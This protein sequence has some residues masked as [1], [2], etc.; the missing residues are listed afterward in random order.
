MDTATD[1]RAISAT[2]N[3]PCDWGGAFKLRLFLAAL[4][5]FA[6]TGCRTASPPCDFPAISTIA[7]NSLVT[8]TPIIDIH[9][10]SFDA[11]DI[12][13][14]MIALGR[15][16]SVWTWWVPDSWARELAAL[17]VAETQQDNHTEPM[18]NH[19]PKVLNEALNRLGTNVSTS[20]EHLK[21]S[22][23][24][25]A[26]R[27]A[28]EQRGR[29]L[30]NER[31]QIPL[32]LGERFALHQ[33][34]H[35]MA[36]EA[37]RSTNADS[38]LEE[39][40]AF[41]YDLTCSDEN[42][43]DHRF[44]LE[45]STNIVFRIS[46]MMD[47]APTYGQKE[48]EELVPFADQISHMEELQHQPRAH[49]AYFVAYNPY[50]DNKN[51]G[52]ALRLVK[53][54]LTEHHAYGVKV[55]SPGGYQPAA[56]R[57]PRRPLT[58]WHKAPAKE[59]DSRYTE[60]GKKITGQELDNRMFELLD[61]CASNKIPVFVHCMN[62]E[63]KA[64][65]NYHRM[66]DPRWWRQVLETHPSL[67]N[68]YLCLG[69]AGGEEWWFGEK[70]KQPWGSN[71]YYLCTNYPNVY[72]EFGDL[73]GIFTQANQCQFASNM[74]ALC[75]TNAATGTS[76]PFSKKIMYGSDW[77]MPMS[78]GRKEYLAAF[79]QVFLSEKMPLVYYRRFFFENAL[80]YLN[81]S[82]RLTDS[83][84]PID[85]VVAE[86]LANLLSKSESGP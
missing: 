47:M 54:A 85:S 36:G 2:G 60:N 49:M 20:Y 3:R 77:F 21:N 55:Y 19:E 52:E 71:V 31:N 73:E 83:K 65:A 13:V 38:T 39:V 25:W 12:P 84:F 78:E 44:Y 14:K 75:A 68:L 53:D 74:L 51:P 22:S 61:W 10:H 86:T 57:I 15:R 40:G 27:D 7:T 30:R 70:T 58:W 33:I 42:L 59:W 62:S 24:H 4:M 5:F 43:V 64:R 9:T 6:W 56:N 80:K 28:I 48:E 63:M 23:M 16:D 66:A 46:H 79:Q 34:L 29:K 32:T 17:I 1:R 41:L 26:V 82:D 72:C 67:T 8:N 35:Y 37:D 76:Y 18:T 81:A 69:H 11:R 45:N 50:R